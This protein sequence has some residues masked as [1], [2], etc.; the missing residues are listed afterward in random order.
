MGIEGVLSLSIVGITLVVVIWTH[1]FGIWCWWEGW[2]AARKMFPNA[3]DVNQR[4]TFAKRYAINLHYMR[5]SIR[6]M[7]GHK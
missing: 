4:T 3:R 6:A 2:K 1:R 7:R 5:Y